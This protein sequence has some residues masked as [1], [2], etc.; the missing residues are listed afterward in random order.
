MFTHTVDNA[1]NR[2]TYKGVEIAVSYDDC[3]SNPLDDM[4]IQGFAIRSHER[5]TTDYDPCGT[6]RDYQ[7]LLD[8]KDNTLCVIGAVFDMLRERYGKAWWEHV[9]EDDEEYAKRA[10]YVIDDI[11]AIDD[12]D[13]QLESYEVYEYVAYDEYGHP[14]YTVVVDMP[15]F[16][17]AWG[18]SCSEYKDIALSIAKDYAA[19]ANGSVYVIGVEREDEEADYT[20][21]VIGVDVYD[22]EALIE[23]AENYYVL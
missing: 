11:A 21:G 23:F 14:R 9:D 22:D 13:S 1:I 18:P 15:L 6:M 3:A 8:D 12:Y 4:D 19:W 7:G 5:N 10:Q 16:K 17:L 2:V 20:Y